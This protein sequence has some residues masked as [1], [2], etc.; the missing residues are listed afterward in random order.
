MTTSAAAP[1]AAPAFT[2]RDVMAVFLAT[3]LAR[4]AGNH[5]MADALAVVE[6][7][8]EACFATMRA[9]GLTVEAR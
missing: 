5:T 9:A 3:D 1:V 8:I 6:A 7:K 2:Q 4:T